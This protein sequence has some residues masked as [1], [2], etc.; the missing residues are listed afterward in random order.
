M[1]RFDDRHLWAAY[2]A[3]VE[4]DEDPRPHAAAIVEFHM[5]FIRDYAVRTVWRSMDL[6]EYVAELVVVVMGLVPRFD[7]DHDGRQAKFVTFFRPYLQEVRWKMTAAAGDIP[8]GKE[9]RRMVAAVE[10]LQREAAV[11]GRPEPTLEELDDYVSKRLGKRIGVGRIQ[12]ALAMPIVIRGDALAPNHEGWP[13]HNLHDLWNTLADPGP[14]PEDE[15]LL[16]IQQAELDRAVTGALAAAEL[17]D[18]DKALV[19]ERLMAPPRRCHDGQEL[20]PG[21]TPYRHLADRYGMTT[22]D[23]RTAE[24]NLVSRLRDLLDGARQ[25]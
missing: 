1:G 2:K 14:S 7:P 25:Q 24:E 5:G 19:A 23:V 13:N 18:L 21:P 12:R 16:L 8:H 15:A 4:A 22:A 10:Q 6:D 17:T 20:T 3:A 11:A 9:T